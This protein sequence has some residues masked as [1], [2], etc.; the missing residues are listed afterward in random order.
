M[1][2]INR[3]IWI[4]TVQNKFKLHIPTALRE[5]FKVKEQDQ[6]VFIQEGDI[7]YIKPI[8]K[9]LCTEM[10]DLIKKKQIRSD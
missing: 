7:I 3:K 8:D 9:E 5:Y 2:K 6:I 10:I 1:T 4:A